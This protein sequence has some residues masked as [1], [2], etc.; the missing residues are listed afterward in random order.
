MTGWHRIAWATVE[1]T[2][3]R[4]KVVVNPR[5]PFRLIK[6][7]SLGADIEICRWVLAFDTGSIQDLSVH[8]LLRGDE[9]R[10][11]STA[12][13]RLTGVVVDYDARVAGWRGRIEIWG[14]L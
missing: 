6:L 10:A 3:G 14:Q 5:G 9:S 8:R 2:N 11:M 7:R 4:N 12:G 1:N 13:R